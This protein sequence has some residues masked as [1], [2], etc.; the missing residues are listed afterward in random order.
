[1][2]ARA[3]RLNGQATPRRPLR[4]LTASRFIAA[5]VVFGSHLVER[6][7]SPPLDAGNFLPESAASAVGYFFVLSGFVL[8]LGSGTTPRPVGWWRKRLAR[9]APV[10]VV[11]GMLSVAFLTL[12]GRPPGL[13]ESVAFFTAT[14]AWFLSTTFAI[15]PP[16][17]SVSCEAFFYALM[18]AVALVVARFRRPLPL[19][20]ATVGTL[21]CHAALT[22]S[23]HGQNP[24][25]RLPEFLLGVSLGALFSLDPRPRAGVPAAALCVVGTQVALVVGVPGLGA[26]VGTLALVASALLVWELAA[27]DV[28]GRAPPPRWLVTLG[29]WSYSFY[30][31]HYLVLRVLA[32]AT[33]HL[34]VTAPTPPGAT[35]AESVTA[36]ALSLTAAGILHHVVECPAERRLR[37]TA[38]RTELAGVV[39]G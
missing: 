31:V 27:W 8:S 12:Q 28:G 17:W 21:V 16:A 33:G 38:P 18:P 13:V 7:P 14:Q 11:T 22:T 36:L 34:G 30:L 20:M 9:V 26:T 15:N 4:S 24:L 3:G 39:D 10:Y 29:L 23:S 25:V 32:S 35:V 37:G 2:A 6:F 1:M 19:A 5:L